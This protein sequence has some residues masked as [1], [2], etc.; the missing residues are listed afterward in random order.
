[1]P[2]G[3]ALGLLVFVGGIILIIAVAKRIKSAPP[4]PSAD[5]ADEVAALHAL[6][7]RMEERIVVLERI[8]DAE[9]SGWRKRL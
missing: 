9:D 3:H 1:M 2:F 5:A 4:R 8:L 7:G 6:I